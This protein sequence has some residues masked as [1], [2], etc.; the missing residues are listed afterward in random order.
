MAGF[1]LFT[2]GIALIVFRT[3]L[4]GFLLNGPNDPHPIFLVNKGAETTALWIGGLI[5]QLGIGLI[6]AGA[7][8]R[9]PGTTGADTKGQS[10][11]S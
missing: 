6:V 10:S 9:K 4:T 1:V 7:V 3:P 11:D 5:A 2:A 8:K